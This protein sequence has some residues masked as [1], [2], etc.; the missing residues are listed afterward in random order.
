[1]DKNN[2]NPETMI[3]TALIGAKKFVKKSGGKNK[4]IVPRIL[5]IP[6][7]GGALP[8]IPIFAGLSTLGT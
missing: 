7:Q 8:L 6:T 5:P 1:M 4:I 3:Q 2:K